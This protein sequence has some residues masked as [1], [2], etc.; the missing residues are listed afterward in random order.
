MPTDLKV[1]SPR[2]MSHNYARPHRFAP[3]ATGVLHRDLVEAD[4]GVSLGSLLRTP[5]TTAVCPLVNL[6]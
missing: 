6:P 1:P 4:A 3:C 5:Y 2:P